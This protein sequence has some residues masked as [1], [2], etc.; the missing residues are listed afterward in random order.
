MVTQWEKKKIIEW[1]S[2]LPHKYELEAV[3]RY[4]IFKCGLVGA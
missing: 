4:F 2:E 3:E 1:T